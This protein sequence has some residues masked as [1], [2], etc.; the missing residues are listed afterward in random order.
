MDLN[1]YGYYSDHLLESLG[2][3]NSS[4]LGFTA[5]C[6]F[7]SDM[8]YSAWC[9]YSHHL[10]GCVGVRHGE[11]AVFNTAMSQQE[12]DSLVPKIIDHMVSTGEW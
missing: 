7:S 2:S 5:C 1:G 10:F 8:Y 9:T 6:D 4:R 3:G 12:Y 11:H